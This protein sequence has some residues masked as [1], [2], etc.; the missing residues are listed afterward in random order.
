MPKRTVTIRPAEASDADALAAMWE[1]MTGQHIAYDAERWDW[2]ADH[3]AAWRK[4][5][6]ETLDDADTICLVAEGEAGEVSGYALAAIT[7]PPSIWA[8]RRRGEIGDLFVRE[9]RRRQGVGTA[10]MAAALEAM[11]ARG[12][13]DVLLRVSKDNEAAIR[14]YEHHGLRVVVH[15]MYRRL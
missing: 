7:T 4:E 9:D 6:H 3:A 15:E 11:K 13:E 1:A 14:H 8:T 12:A 2:S 5:F 10:L